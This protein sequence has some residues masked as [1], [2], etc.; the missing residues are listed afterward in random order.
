MVDFCQS[1][2]NIYFDC[3][4]ESN[5]ENVYMK[6]QNML[7]P[8]DLVRSSQLYEQNIKYG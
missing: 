8:V 1:I 4:N 7:E 2:Q 6:Q 5:F 3:S